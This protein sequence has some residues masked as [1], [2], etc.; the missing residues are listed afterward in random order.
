MSAGLAFG[1]TAALALAV[2]GCGGAGTTGSGDGA[3]LWQGGKT[4]TDGRLHAPA[5]PLRLADLRREPQGSPR[6]TILR[7]FYFAQWGS[8]PNIP[9][10]YD[11]A[12]RRTV[13]ATNIVGTYIQQR[14]SLAASRLRM[15]ESTKTS[16]GTFV[17]VELLRA[18]APPERHSFS[19]RKR[20][21]HWRIV[22]DTLL[23]QGLVNYVSSMRSRTPVGQP[24]DPAAM[25]RGRLAAEG[26]RRLFAS[27]LER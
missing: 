2:V 18:D 14:A 25:T 15:I 27:T 23:E 26:Y 4:S 5:Q 16:T 22:Y 12:V 21:G 3:S 9:T 8:A 20:S 13:G 7:L 24:A 11:R 6:A 10:A 17:S 19:L 1:M